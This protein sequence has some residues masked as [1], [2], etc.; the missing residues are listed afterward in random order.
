MLYIY[1]AGG[2]S[3]EVYDIALS[4]GH[5]RA[6][7]RL[8]DD[9]P[10][11]SSILSYEQF[12]S[13]RTKSDKLVVA[14]GEPSVRAIL[15]DKLSLLGCRFKSLIHPSAIISESARISSGSIICPM[16]SISSN[17]YIGNNVVVNTLSI[18]G[19]DVSI[20]NHSVLS[21]MVNIGGAA[22]VYEQVYVGM[23]ALVRERVSLSDHSVVSMGSVVHRDVA[24]RVIVQ[25][26]PAKPRL[27]NE[28]GRIFKR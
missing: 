1:C 27:M 26:D 16:C 17:A 12:L 4:C 13:N 28:H 5:N 25:G 10:L 14:H 15:Y 8:V 18:V 24:E 3:R 6:D 20:G 7:I 11:D 2:F 23:G 19:H 22:N 21:S 9:C